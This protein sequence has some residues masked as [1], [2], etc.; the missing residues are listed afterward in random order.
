MLLIMPVD[1]KMLMNTDEHDRE[2]WMD[3]WK[4]MIRDRA[5][6]KESQWTTA[7]LERV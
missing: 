4:M 1:L 7:Q 2:R 6:H 3:G 5:C